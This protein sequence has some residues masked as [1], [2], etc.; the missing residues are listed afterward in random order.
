MYF[1]KN[2]SNELTKYKLAWL[3]R[4]YV[5]LNLCISLFCDCSCGGAGEHCL[6]MQR[7]KLCCLLYEVYALPGC[8][9][10]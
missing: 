6:L 9:I 1:F 8:Y 5:L 4:S 10:C 3:Y 2:S 7:D